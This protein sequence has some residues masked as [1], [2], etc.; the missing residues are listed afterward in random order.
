MTTGDASA[1][2]ATAM[3]NRNSRRLLLVGL[4]ALS[5]G[6]IFSSLILAP[7]IAAPAPWTQLGEF[8]I[9]ASLGL[10]LSTKVPVS[11]EFG[12]DYV[13]VRR[14]YGSRSFGKDT[15]TRAEYR[16]LEPYLRKPV[17]DRYYS[18]SLWSGTRRVADLGVDGAVALRFMAWFDPTKSTLKVYRGRELVEERPLES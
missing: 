12:P 18:V 2:A 14:L 6:W 16:I 13:L 17:E 10:L 7:A 4:V 8:V 3:S 1:I 5:V 15:I 11:I 9:F